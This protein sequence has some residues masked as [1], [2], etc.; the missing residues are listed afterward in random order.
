MLKTTI[1]DSEHSLDVPCTQHRSSGCADA[2][3]CPHV[4]AKDYTQKFF[5]QLSSLK[6]VL[7]PQFNSL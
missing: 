7:R 3:G 6:R 5:A 4:N 2:S 1:L